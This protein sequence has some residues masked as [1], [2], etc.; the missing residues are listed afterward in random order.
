MILS[1]KVRV[2]KSVCL[3]DPNDT[4]KISKNKPYSVELVPVYDQNINRSANDA[5]QLLWFFIVKLI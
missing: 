1:N 4:I 2:H 5:E 3:T